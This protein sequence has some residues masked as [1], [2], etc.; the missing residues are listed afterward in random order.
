MT[1]ESGF[2]HESFIAGLSRGPGVYQMRDSA[3][4]SIYIG[5]AANLRNRVRSYFR[6]GALNARSLAMMSRVAG[7]EVTITDNETEALLLEQS[8]IKRYRPTYNIQLR[9][10]KSYPYILLTEH[11]DFPRLSFYRGSRRGRGTHY[12]PYPSAHSTRDSLN[13]LQKVF[14]VRQCEDSYF[15]NRSRPCLQHQIKR[16]TAPCVGLVSKEDYAE[17]VRFSKLFLEG[18]SDRLFNELARG[19]EAAADREQFEKAAVIRDR[20]AAL[21][22]IQD[23]QVVANKGGNADII[24]AVL[25]QPYACVHV[26]HVRSGRIIDSKSHFPQYRLARNATEIVAAFISQVYLADDKA[27]LM[28]GE[29]IIPELPE[30]AE[31]IE[32]ALAYVAGRKVK[33]ASRVR[34]HRAKWLE[35]ASVNARQSLESLL[36]SRRN[37]RRRLRLLQRALKLEKIPGR[38]ECFD[39]S[40]TAGRETVASAVVFDENGPARSDYRRFN[41][42]CERPLDSH[43]Q[44]Q[45]SQDES[46]RT[47][48]RLRLVKAS[49]DYAAMEQVLRRRFTRLLA[50]EGK[51]PDLVLIDGGKGQLASAASALAELGAPEMPLLAIAKGISRRAGQETLFLQQGGKTREIALDGIS[52]ALHLLQQVRD[53]AHRFAIAGHRR[54]RA[55]AG[56][57][58]FLEGIPGI[59]P[60]R[61]RELLRHFGGRRQLFRASEAQLADV[62]GI[63]GQL[64]GV[65]YRHLHGPT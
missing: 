13:V 44:P 27:S 14:Q 45:D 21:R 1:P 57:Q 61:R 17:Q 10:D 15:N 12:G 52:P 30:E 4:K 16:C 62:N 64:A 40:H 41:I 32:A 29:V 55:K 5:K 38:L 26:I 35:M 54:R 9:D 2:D 43:E 56:K 24:A 50:G 49:D 39:I 28:P 42:Q 36:A 34:S 63:S 51:M 23:K 31:K 33:L 48:G 25:D 19:M 3:G 6:G 65:I 47:P 22:R 37:I 8:L 11:Q 46:H 58:S 60:A 7:I 18:K 59:G 20:I 53:E